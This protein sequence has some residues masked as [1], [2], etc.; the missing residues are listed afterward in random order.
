MAVLGSSASLLKDI[1]PL[2]ALADLQG[3]LG[4]SN[5][6]IY[7]SKQTEDQAP[8]D[9]SGDVKVL[10]E[11]EVSTNFLPKP[12]YLLCRTMLSTLVSYREATKI[13]FKKS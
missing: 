13:S 3:P 12:G 6:T 1:L 4:E 10:Y 8:L 7:I 2:C 11:L 5:M 9:L